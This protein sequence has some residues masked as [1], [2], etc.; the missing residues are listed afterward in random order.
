MLNKCYSVNCIVYLEHDLHSLNTKLVKGGN[1][2]RLLDNQIVLCVSIKVMY[3]VC[4]NTWFS[5]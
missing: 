3:S 4:K 5:R 1:D 2:R